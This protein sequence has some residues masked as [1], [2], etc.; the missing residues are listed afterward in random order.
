MKIELEE[1]DKRRGKIIIVF[2]IGLIVGITIASQDLGFFETGG[3]ETEV[4]IGQGVTGDVPDQCQDV[5]P[6]EVDMCIANYAIESNEK[7]LCHD[8]QDSDVTNYCLG[9]IE[10]DEEI[11]RDIELDEE[12]EQMCLQSV[13]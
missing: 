8:A 13:R 7:E 11:C 6:Y 1:S 2:L 9:I 10:Q 3:P 4:E 5:E 12:L